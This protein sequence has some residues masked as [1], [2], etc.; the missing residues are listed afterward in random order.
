VQ[1]LKEIDSHK[2]VWLKH[3]PELTDSIVVTVVISLITKR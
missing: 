1:Q 3:W 2:L